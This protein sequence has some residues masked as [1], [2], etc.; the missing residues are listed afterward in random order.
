MSDS[1]RRA[2][3]IGGGTGLPTVL[4]CLIALG[5]NTS[6]VVTMADDGGSTGLLRREL[7]MLPPGDIRNCLVALGDSEALLSRL[8]QY[9]FPHGE[10]LAGHALGNLVLAALTDITGSFPDAIAF[11]AELLGARGNALPCTLEDVHLTAVDAAGRPVRGQSTI[12]VSNGPIADVTLDPELPAAYEPAIEAIVHADVIV[13]GPGSLFT[14]IIP[15]FLVARV[16]DMVRESSATRVYVCNVANQRGET[17]GMDAVDHVTALVDHGLAGGLDVVL[18]HDTDAYPV[19]VSTVSGYD[20]SPHP[21]DPVAAGSEVVE[22]IEA[23][24]MRVVTA[25]LADGDNPLHHD[26]ARLLEALREVV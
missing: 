21:V 18:V 15:N 22:R 11:A 12:A 26:G 17:A 23:M 4:A 14:S 7:G 9:R 13:I 25:E 20:G 16:A 2:A 5:F 24:G 1:V 6:A 3:A 19:R 10:G 8:F